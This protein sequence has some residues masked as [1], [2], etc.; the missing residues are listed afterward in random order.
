MFEILAKS[1]DET[2]GEIM[3]YGNIA[4]R[5]YWED[6]DVVT[7][8]SFDSAL[9]ELGAK[10]RNL[11]VRVN[12]HGGSVFAG[13]AIVTMIDTARDR[14]VAVTSVIE[15]IGAS[16]GSVIPQAA[17]KV[18]MAKNAMLMVHKPSTLAFGNADDLLDAAAMLEKAEKTLVGLYMRRF[19]GTE[20][21]LKA[22][23]K[24]DV[25]GT[26]MTADEALD[27]GFVD[28][29]T[30]P[31][32]MAA[33]AE[34]YCINGIVVP[35]LALKGAEDKI[36]IF[37]KGGEKEMLYSEKIDAKIK[38]LLESGK[39]VAVVRDSAAE[40]GFAVNEVQD[41]VLEGAGNFL[42]A[43]QAR[44]ALGEEVNAKDILHI[45]AAAKENSMT[46]EDVA[47]E[48]ANFGEAAQADAE[49]VG[50]AEKYKQLFEKAVKD[51]LENGVRAE[52]NDFDSEVWQKVLNEM[53]YEKVVAQSEKW[54]DKFEENV[55]AG[56]KRL[57]VDGRGVS[58]VMAKPEDYEF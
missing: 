57:S 5:R 34:G 43:G 32:E 36:Q 11:T 27:Y 4:D 55:H 46:L 44:E 12:S 42:T 56:K 10:L 14:G 19:K 45:L 38:S 52:G 48:L 37:H 3:V 50:Y 30:E 25:D 9:K 47:K 49:T 13:Q 39:A 20:D 2:N 26:W 53:P 29:V 24:G 18:V 40:D 7:P 8:K 1:I 21:E 51:A 41:G 22:L 33:C 6:E 16:M 17:D 28:E 23:L 31:V 15:G 54:L 58:P 35:A